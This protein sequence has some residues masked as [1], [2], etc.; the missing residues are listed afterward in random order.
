M[1]KNDDGG[2][3]TMTE[4]E[5]VGQTE[6]AR[7]TRQQPNGPDKKGHDHDWTG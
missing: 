5:L 3:D 1:K 7:R 4:M 2:R 6:M